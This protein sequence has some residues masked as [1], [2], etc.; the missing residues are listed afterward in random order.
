MG[1]SYNIR[2]LIIYYYIFANYLLGNSLVGSANRIRINVTSASI[3]L[4][5]K[6]AVPKFLP[7]TRDR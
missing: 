3:P 2:R 1:S 6:Q 7:L 4:K 5:W